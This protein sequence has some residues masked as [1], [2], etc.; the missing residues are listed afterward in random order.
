MGD[1]VSR[2]VLLLFRDATPLSLGEVHVRRWVAFV[3]K[4]WVKAMST[5]ILS[6]I[7]TVTIDLKGAATRKDCKDPATRKEDNEI[8]NR[9]PSDITLSHPV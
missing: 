2:R 9:I 3:T 4:W 6:V 5:T 8:F 7:H 1:H